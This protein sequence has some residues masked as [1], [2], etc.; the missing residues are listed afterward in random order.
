MAAGPP[1]RGQFP[2][3]R[4]LKTGRT[5]AE[6]VE[7]D[8]K[9]RQTVEG[10]LADF[11]ARGDAAVREMSEKF[12]KWSP[13]AFRLSDEQ[14]KALIATLPAQTITDIEFAQAQVRRF[15]QAQRAAL[16][17]IEVETLPG[18]RLGHKNI[19]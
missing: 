12:D 10:L 4:Y 16:Q 13:A 18:V 3:I 6:N 14:I 5:E 2:M 8:R 19:P 11:A 1:N 7:A 9:V 17:D 15:A